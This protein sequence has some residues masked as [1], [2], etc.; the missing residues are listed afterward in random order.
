MGQS[1]DPSQNEDQS[2]AVVAGEKLKVKCESAKSRVQE[3]DVGEERSI[4]A[5]A[6]DRPWNLMRSVVT[7]SYNGKNGE[8]R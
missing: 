4:Y 2:A 6:R 5:G 8:C 1:Q 7:L 3:G